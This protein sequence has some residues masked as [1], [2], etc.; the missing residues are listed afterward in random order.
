MREGH[1]ATLPDPTERPTVPVEEAGEILGISRNSAYEGVKS[2]EI[3]SIRVGRRIMVPT[4]GLRR[5]LLVDD[6]SPAA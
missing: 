5:M 4:A 3:P 1:S 6:A 2:G